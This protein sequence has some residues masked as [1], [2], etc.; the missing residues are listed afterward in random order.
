MNEMSP[1]TSAGLAAIPFDA[2]RLDW[3]ME[4]RDLDTLI[5]TSKHNI[6]YLFG[7]Y[8]FFFFSA[9]DAIGVSRYLP[10]FVYRRGRPELSFYAGCALENYEAQL[11]KFWVPNRALTCW[12]T[13]QSAAAIVAHLRKIGGT[14][15]IGVESGFLPHDAAAALTEG[16]PSTVMLDAH[17]LLERLRA[18]K[19]PTE[20]ALLKESSERVVAAIMAVFAGH[21]PGV[22]KSDLNEALRLEETRRGMTFEYCLLTAGTS[23]NRSP[24]D[25]RIEA[26]DI[27]SLDSGGNYH[28][29]IGDL[30][31]MGIAGEPDQELIDL[32]AEVDA[33]Q[34][35]ARKPIRAGVLGQ[36]IYDHA[37][38]TRAVQPHGGITD[39]MAHGM[40]LIAHEA[41]RLTSTGPIPYAGDDARL[42][43]EAGMII[44]I[45]TTLPHPR[46]GFVKL[47]D[48]VIVTET[49]CEGYG[50]AGRGWNR[51]QG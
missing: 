30:C 5:V 46:R 4:E 23:L 43:L 11:D 41:P 25:Q 27:V 35:A 22:T 33:T 38:A 1:L 9:M 17:I 10:A 51:M 37:L 7:G 42:P 3:L 34:M 49:G 29:Y 20:Q 26:G 47:E 28:G 21:G 16:L 13:A 15:R 6:R 45:E 50:D 18:I 44:S 36:D 12:T 31:R 14:R 19:T 39:F 32:L 2:A 40:G 8:H 24:S 48:T